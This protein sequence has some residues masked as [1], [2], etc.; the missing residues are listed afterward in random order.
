MDDPGKAVATLTIDELAQATAT[1]TDT[2]RAW[3][4]L[5]L[6]SSRGETLRDEDIER[7]RLLEFVR[8]R[9]ITPEAVARACETQGDLLGDFVDSML[10]GHL[11]GPVV[12]LTDAAQATGLEPGLLERLWGAAGLGDQRHADAD[13]LGALRALRTALD[14]GLPAD[15][16]VQIVRV[17]AA[18][19]SSPRR[20]PSATRSSG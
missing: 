1:S 16:L 8:Q 18:A 14:V 19:G 12:S 5:G 9:G 2:L 7:V 11:P 4:D 3:Q 17:F 15:A 6:L 20:A 10:G 13:D